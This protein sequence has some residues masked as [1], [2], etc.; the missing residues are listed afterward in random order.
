MRR[1]TG[2]GAGAAADE[3]AG[4]RVSAWPKVTQ[5]ALG[6]TDIPGVSPERLPPRQDPTH[7]NPKPFTQSAETFCTHPPP[8]T[9]AAAPRGR[10]HWR[11]GPSPRACPLAR[12]R[13]HVRGPLRPAAGAPQAPMPRRDHRQPVRQ[14]RR[15]R[16]VK[17]GPQGRICSSSFRR[18]S[19]SPAWSRARSPAR[20]SASAVL[21][22]SKNRCC[23]ARR[24]RARRRRQDPPRARRERSHHRSRRSSRPRGAAVPAR[25]FLPG[26]R[27]R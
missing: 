24:R 11:K 8:P 21:A 15:L 7:S 26:R 22:E 2:A 14:R 18:T 13:T 1:R 12:Y 5:K 6:R 27:L 4:T 17:R 10:P 9:H 20:R 19:A 3:N 25:G 16:R 23:S